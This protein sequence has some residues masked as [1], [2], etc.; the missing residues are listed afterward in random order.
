MITEEGR[1]D[2]DAVERYLLLL[3]AVIIRIFRSDDA[4]TTLIADIKATLK[5]SEFALVILIPSTAY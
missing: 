1:C 3:P 4:E 2:T 5:L